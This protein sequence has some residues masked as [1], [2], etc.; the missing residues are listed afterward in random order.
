[1]TVA[2]IFLANDTVVSVTNVAESELGSRV[3][4]RKISTNVCTEFVIDIAFDIVKKILFD[5][6]SMFAILDINGAVYTKSG[7]MLNKLDLK[8]TLIRDI[9]VHSGM[10]CVVADNFTA[11]YKNSQL[12]V[13]QETCSNTL[14]VCSLFATHLVSLGLQRGTIRL[15]SFNTSSGDGWVV[16]AHTSGVVVIASTSTTIATVSEVGSLIRV[17]SVKDGSLLYELRRSWLVASPSVGKL[18][19][20]EDGLIVTLDVSGQLCV[21]KRSKTQLQLP[22]SIADAFIVDNTLNLITKTNLFKTAQINAEFAIE[23]PSDWIILNQ[24][25]D[26]ILVREEL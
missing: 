16:S 5:S 22:I 20:N 13:R 26:P 17:R 19:I 14:G 2:K 6:D 15:V 24:G 7:S 23:W 25:T 4:L 1:M 21:L 8:T 11:V 3:E 10:L 12:M 18:F 9:R